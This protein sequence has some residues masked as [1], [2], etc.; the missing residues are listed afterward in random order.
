MY[1]YYDY[2]CIFLDAEAYLLGSDPERAIFMFG[3]ERT[4]KEFS[5]SQF[6]SCDGTFKVKL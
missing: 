1:T 3:S 6:K 4:L 5:H 2:F